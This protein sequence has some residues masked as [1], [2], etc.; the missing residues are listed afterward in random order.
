MKP[1]EIRFLR[2]KG[3]SY[4]VN[5]QAGRPLEAIAGVEDL[6]AL[7]GAAIFAIEDALQE[8]GALHGA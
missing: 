8:G 1:I 6:M 2:D 4:L 3:L 7:A 5:L